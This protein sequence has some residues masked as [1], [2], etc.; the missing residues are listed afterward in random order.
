MGRPL[1]DSDGKRVRA[2]QTIAFSYGIPPVY[3]RG[4]VVRRGNRLTV[5]TEG[6]NPSECPVSDLMDCV[7]DFWIIE[8]A[9]EAVAT[10]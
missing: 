6:H 10:E 5:I 3:V 1:R 7:G 4:P 9:T 8:P 2:G